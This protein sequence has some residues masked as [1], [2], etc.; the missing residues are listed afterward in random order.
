MVASAIPDSIVKGRFML[1]QQSAGPDLN[2]LVVDG[3]ADHALI[4][5][6]L[7][8]EI[9]CFEATVK[10][11]PGPDVART[12]LMEGPFDVCLVTHR[13]HLRELLA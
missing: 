3:D 13:R 5:E 2:V 12:M 10:W 7:L 9:P 4:I 8:G 6:Q 1:E 11:A